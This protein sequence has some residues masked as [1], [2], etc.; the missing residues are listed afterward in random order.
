MGRRSFL[1]L[2]DRLRSLSTLDDPLETLEGLILWGDFRPL[3]DKA[4]KRNAGR[5]PIDMM[6]MFKVLIL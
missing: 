2:E 5:R 6:L 4:R 3:L 1:G